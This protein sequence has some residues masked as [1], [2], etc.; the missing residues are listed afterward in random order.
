ML[1]QLKRLPGLAALLVLSGCGSLGSDFLYQSSSPTQK[2]NNRSTV[3]LP[4]PEAQSL[5]SYDSADFNEPTGP[6]TLRQALSLVVLRSPELV[7]S[8]YEIRSAEARRLQAG[9]PPNPEVELGVAEFGGTGSRRG[10]GASESSLTLSQLIELGGKRQLRSNVA[11]RDRDLAN[12]S[13][14]AKRLDVLL[15]ATHAFIDVIAAQRMVALAE[16]AAG[17]SQQVIDTVTARVEAGKISPLEQT[18]ARVSFSTSQLALQRARRELRIAREQLTAMWASDKPTFAEAQGD[19]ETLQVIPQLGQLAAQTEN[20][21]DLAR[22]RTEI[23]QREEALRLE[24]AK[25]IPDPKLSIGVT[26]FEDSNESAFLVGLSIPIP[27]FGINPGGVR[28]AEIALAQSAAERRGMEIKVAT[29]LSR[30]YELLASSYSEVAALQREVLPAAEQAFND[31]RDGYRAGKFGFLEVLDAQRA[32][33]ES[34]GSYIEALSNYHKSLA[35]VERLTGRPLKP[36]A[37]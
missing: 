23:E 22:W 7:T 16:D 29:A 35:E 26:R 27:L 18:R 31:A 1:R 2:A 30:A 6:L 8:S 24:R 20:N 5:A 36:A 15:E 4:T 9:L 19:Y 28:E 21:P 11:D 17:I 13:Y 10:F 12:W 32:L 14:E 25:N 3:A 37:Q 33:V 34:R